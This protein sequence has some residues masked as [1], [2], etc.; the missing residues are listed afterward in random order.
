M[1]PNCCLDWSSVCMWKSAKMMAGQR[2][3]AE[4]DGSTEENCERIEYRGEL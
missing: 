2:M 1:R 3:M 4:D